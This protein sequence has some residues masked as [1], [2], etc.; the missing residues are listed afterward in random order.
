MKMFMQF[1]K[2]FRIDVNI[3]IL[4]YFNCNFTILHQPC[5]SIVIRVDNHSMP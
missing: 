5:K 3:P 1:N 4:T 2:I